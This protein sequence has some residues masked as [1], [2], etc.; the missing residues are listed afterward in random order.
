MLALLSTQETTAQFLTFFYWTELYRKAAEAATL[1]R[2]A[3]TSVLLLEQAVV[4][5]ESA[6]T[7]AINIAVLRKEME[8]KIDHWV[9]IQ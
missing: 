7:L 8:D 9:K 5:G 2:K 4:L 1:G 6:S 3:S